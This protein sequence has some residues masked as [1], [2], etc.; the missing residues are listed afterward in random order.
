MAGERKVFS[1]Q[2]VA[3]VVRRAV[4]LQEQ[5]G[6]EA[7]MP[8]VTTEELQ[9]IAGDLGIDPKYLQ[10]AVD[11]AASA[12]EAR[13]K[14]FSFAEEYERVV[15]AEISPD[16]Y[17]VLL[18]H[19]PSFGSRHPITQVGRT[20]TGRTWTGCSIANVE[21][22]SKRG[23]TRI[24]VRSNSLFA[25]LVTIYPAFIASLVSL[26]PL[27]ESG[28][29][30]IALAFIVLAVSVAALGFRSLTKRGHRASKK[31]ADRLAESVLEDADDAKRHS[32]TTQSAATTGESIVQRLQN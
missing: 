3:A 2:E 10:Q 25:F 30:W 27:T 23:R 17:D 32:G 16:D 13:R 4:E 8:G 29:L 7:Y 28:H 11:E 15:D 22:T 31:L 9:R 24:R 21:V 14:P 18:K 6:H 20:L 19:I 5:A 1:E 12:D 26:G